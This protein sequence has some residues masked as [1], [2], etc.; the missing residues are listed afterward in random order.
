M[1]A[2]S[3][4]VDCRLADPT[5]TVGNLLGLYGH[6]A[7]G[8]TFLAWQRLS[9]LA[10]LHSRLVV[11]PVEHGDLRLRDAYL[12]LA[13]RVWM[14]RGQSADPIVGQVDDAVAMRD[15]LPLTGLCL[16]DFRTPCTRC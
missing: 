9:V 1:S 5:V 13:H 4:G 2:A 14:T 10:E 12:Q 7:K 15:R 11:P 6:A 3:L 16:R 8:D